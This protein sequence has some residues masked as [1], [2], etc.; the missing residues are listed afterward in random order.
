MRSSKV[1]VAAAVSRDKKAKKEMLEQFNGDQL[2]SIFMKASR[3]EK[4]LYTRKETSHYRDFV[5][6][7]Y[8]QLC[9]RFSC[10]PPTIHP[11]DTYFCSLACEELYEWKLERMRNMKNKLRTNP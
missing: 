2:W 11:T 6:H 7:M 1:E 8:C 4:L 5:K 3:T 10:K 9:N